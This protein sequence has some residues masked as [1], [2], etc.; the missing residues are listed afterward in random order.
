M[1]A[2]NFEYLDYKRFDGGAGG[3]KRKRDVSILSR[4]AAH[5]VK[6]DE[7]ALKKT[8]IVLEPKAIIKKRKLDQTP[9]V[10]PKIDE[11]AEKTPP[12]LTA[13]EVAEFLKVMTDSPPFKLLSPLGL[14]LTK[15]LQKKHPRLP[16]RRLKDK[17]NDELWI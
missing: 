2:L 8:K 4:Q 16:K 1:D 9:S 14:E 13:A 15:L 6:E 3:V 10:V 7:K 5:S 11:A 12:S 17:R